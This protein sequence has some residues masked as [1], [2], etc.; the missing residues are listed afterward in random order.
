MVDG[1]NPFSEDLW[2]VIKINKLTF[3]GVK[4]CA[5]CKVTLSSFSFANSVTH[6]IFRNL[7]FDNFVNFFFNIMFKVLFS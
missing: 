3:H 2:K 5:R 7:S 4:L 6:E 1:C